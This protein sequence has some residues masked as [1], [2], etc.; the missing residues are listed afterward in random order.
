MSVFREHDTST[1]L[2]PLSRHFPFLPSPMATINLLS[3]LIVHINGVKQHVGF[4]VRLF[5]LSRKFSR[6]IHMEACIRMPRLF[7]AEY[8]VVWIYH[9]LLFIHQVMST[10]IL[11]MSKLRPREGKW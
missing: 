2:H 5:L 7:R 1:H 6:F 9:N 8:S 10:P 4:C 11:Q 3:I